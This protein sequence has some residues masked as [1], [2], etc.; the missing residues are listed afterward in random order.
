MHGT[1]ERGFQI[2]AGSGN[3]DEPGVAEVEE[4]TSPI[5]RNHGLTP[6]ALES[7]ADLSQ[8]D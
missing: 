7:I 1:C 3:D 5:T 2:G 8:G 4:A 6:K